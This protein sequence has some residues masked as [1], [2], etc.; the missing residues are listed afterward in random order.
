MNL[1][2]GQKS[3]RISDDDSLSLNG[4]LNFELS[5][6]TYSDEAEI[7][8][9]IENIFTSIS[10]TLENFNSL[11]QS[12][13]R[14]LQN[15]NDISSSKIEGLLEINFDIN[16]DGLNSKLPFATVTT[17]GGNLNI[18]NGEGTDTKIVGKLPNGKNI[19]VLE[20]GDSWTR[21][22]YTDDNNEEQYGYVSNRYINFNNN[23]NEIK[24]SSSHDLKTNNMDSHSSNNVSLNANTTNN[25]SVNTSH[26]SNLN[27]R[28]GPSTGYGIKRTIS[29]GT[30]VK[31]L[32][33]KG[34]W[35]YVQIGDDPNDVGYVYKK[36]LKEV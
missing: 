26:N 6:G 12:A 23:T 31:I 36:Y 16:L 11:I 8:G 2:T 19:R 28:K 5:G 32:E 20:K 21:I 29:F 14:Y 10:K 33:E 30:K 4:N 24:D 17:S 27:V 34:N 1:E 25:Y 22:A 13:N 9:Y 35:A 15:N 7:I 18:R 3:Q